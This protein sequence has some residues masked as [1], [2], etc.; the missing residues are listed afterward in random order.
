MGARNDQSQRPN[1]AFSG[2]QDDFPNFSRP[3]PAITAPEEIRPPVPHSSDILELKDFFR[4][5]V[6]GELKGSLARHHCGVVEMIKYLIKVTPSFNPRFYSCNVTFCALFHTI[7]CADPGWKPTFG[8][9]AGPTLAG[10]A[11]AVS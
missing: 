5:F 8:P 4:V 3:V 10:A 11:Q 1:D 2:I 7:F 6:I 9:A